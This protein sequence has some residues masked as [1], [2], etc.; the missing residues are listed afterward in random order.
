M[1]R[2]KGFCSRRLSNGPG[3]KFWSLAVLLIADEQQ[4][5]TAC[6][7]IGA[8]A[9]IRLARPLESAK[10][11]SALED[12]IELQQI[13]ADLSLAMDAANHGMVFVNAAGEIVL[14]NSHMNSIFGF[15]ESELIGLTIDNLVPDSLREDHKCLR[16]AY[17]ENRECLTSFSRIVIDRQTKSFRVCTNLF[18]ISWETAASVTTSQRWSF[19]SMMIQRTNPQF[20]REP[21]T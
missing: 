16:E 18:A 1:T 11:L 6:H 17:F 19:K 14:A 20:R 9:V 5:Q 21:V 3:T 12:L 2:V 4:Q 10:T 15:A 8:R 7:A 13:L